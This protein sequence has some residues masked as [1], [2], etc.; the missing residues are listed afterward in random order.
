[1][2]GR[3]G[4]G[5]LRREIPAHLAK[6]FSVLPLF[7]Q[8]GVQFGCFG[9]KLQAKSQRS[10]FWETPIVTHYLATSAGAEKRV[11]ARRA[12][13]VREVPFHRGKGKKTVAG[14]PLA[15]LCL[16][17]PRPAVTQENTAPSRH[18]GLVTQRAL[19]PLSSLSP[20]ASPL[21][22]LEGD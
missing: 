3:C 20:S 6:G 15:L 10:E 4:I 17:D 16:A 2:N 19:S 8:F 9:W 22:F 12:P 1:M 5:T 21:P 13:S 18:P 7:S 11:F 14:S